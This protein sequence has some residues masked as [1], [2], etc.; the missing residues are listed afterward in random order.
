MFIRVITSELK[1]CKNKT[2]L[3]NV[4]VG[5]EIDTDENVD[6]GK[7]KDCKKRIK[8]FIEDQLNGCIIKHE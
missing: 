7:L 4:D 3:Y 1:D 8:S 2:K 5:L 6:F